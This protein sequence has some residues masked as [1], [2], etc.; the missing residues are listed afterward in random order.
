M[1]EYY[2]KSEVNVV[3]QSILLY[4]LTLRDDDVGR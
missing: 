3:S 4:V 2:N 1:T